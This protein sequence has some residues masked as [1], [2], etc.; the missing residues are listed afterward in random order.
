M[1]SVRVCVHVVLRVDGRMSSCYGNTWII[2]GGGGKLQEIFATI[3]LSGGKKRKNVKC[4]Y[5]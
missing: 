3:F 5:F 1:C 4:F 2:C